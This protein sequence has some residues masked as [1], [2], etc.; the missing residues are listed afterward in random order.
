MKQEEKAEYENFQR[1]KK[2]APWITQKQWAAID[3]LS[4]I[5]PFNQPNRSN[6]ESNLS[7]HVEKN[8][9]L[10]YKYVNDQEFLNMAINNAAKAEEAKSKAKRKVRRRA[11]KVSRTNTLT[12]DRESSSLDSS[13]RES[14]KSVKEDEESK[15]D[16]KTNSDEEGKEAAA[17]DKEFFNMQDGEESSE[18][19]EGDEG[20]E[21][22]QDHVRALATE[23]RISRLKRIDTNMALNKGIPGNY[24]DFSYIEAQKVVTELRRTETFIMK[25]LKLGLAQKLL[26]K[27]SSNLSK[28]EHI[29]QEELDEIFELDLSKQGSEGSDLEKMAEEYNYG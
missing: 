8:P 21:E 2:L 7:R 16:K 18:G 23:K 11:T 22:M 6:M 1:R 4:T 10:W 5:P 26:N 3:K 14:I 25:R 29:K 9:D 12:G 27:Q 24:E 20:D 17:G 13:D 19:S 15:E 28:E